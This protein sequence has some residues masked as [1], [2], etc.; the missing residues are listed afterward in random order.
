MTGHGRRAMLI[1]ALVAAA[2]AAAQAQAMPRP[3]AAAASRALTQEVL[4]IFE[5]VCLAA[6]VGGEAVP[7][8]VVRVLGAAAAPLPA[9]QLRGTDQVRETGGWMVSGQFGRYRL[10]TIEPGEQ[11]G[12]L[13]EGVDHDAFLAGTMRIMGRGGD[14]MPGWTATGTPQRQA[15]A[16]PFGTLTYVSANYVGNTTPPRMLTITGSAA[17]RTDGRPNTGVVSSALRDPAR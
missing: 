11:C 10:N 6:M 9:A 4:G 8:V 1:A 13:A 7:A 16:R 3:D 15:G 5:T 14:L 17:A 12:L 2:P